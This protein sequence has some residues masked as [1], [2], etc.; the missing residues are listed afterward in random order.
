MSKV[1][2]D[3]Q[4]WFYNYFNKDKISVAAFNHEELFNNF[5]NIAKNAYL[6]EWFR[7]IHNLHS[8][9]ERYD[10]GEFDYYITGSLFKEVTDFNDGPFKT[11]IEA[12]NKSIVMMHSIISNQ[13]PTM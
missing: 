4:K 1:D 2:L 9:V 12:Q 6:T 11:F 13:K 5:Q 7:E 10:D 3:F 8:Y